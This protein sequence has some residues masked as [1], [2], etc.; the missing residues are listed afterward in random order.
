MEGWYFVS[1]GNTVWGGGDLREKGV[2]RSER[3]RERQRDLKRKRRGQKPSRADDRDG[4]GLRRSL[5]K[6]AAFRDLQHLE[7][8]NNSS[9]NHYV[10]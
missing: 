9:S 3:E 6:G 8:L 10:N 4:K 2:L 5:N 1:V 7:S